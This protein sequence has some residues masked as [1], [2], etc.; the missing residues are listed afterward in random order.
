MRGY[1]QSSLGPRDA[2]G[3]L[4]G[5]RKAVGNAEFLFPVPGLGQDRSARLGVFFDM[6]Q[7]WAENCGM[8]INGCTLSELQLRYSTGVLFSWN[9]PFGPLKLSI[10]QPINDKPG[11]QIQRFQFLF[12]QTF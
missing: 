12:G 5:S 8:T 1:V 9:S 10:A 6:G 3:V 11:D 4:G 7:V 2:Y